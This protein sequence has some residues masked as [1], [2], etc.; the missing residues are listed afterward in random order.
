MLLSHNFNVSPEQVP[1]LS[2]QEFAA[3]L[4]QGLAVH[5]ALTSQ[6]LDHPHWILD[7]RF[8][9]EQLAVQEI[10]AQCAQAL[11]SKRLEQSLSREALPDILV[12]GGLKTTPSTSDSPTA[13]Q[14]GEWGVD[15]VETASSE[16]FLQ[17]IA[18]EATISGK[19][20]ES[21]FKVCLLSTSN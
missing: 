19:P 13:L 21:V 18:W 3:V 9:A 8:P 1:A 20:A 16:V 10:G 14:L 6:I 2:R 12:L 17:A 5:S 15:V 7:V 4:S 11:R